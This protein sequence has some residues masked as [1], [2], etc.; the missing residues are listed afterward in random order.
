MTWDRGAPSQYWGKRPEARRPPAMASA[1]EAVR[2]VGLPPA[3]LKLH[4]RLGSL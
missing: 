2:P 3:H 1:K 4:L